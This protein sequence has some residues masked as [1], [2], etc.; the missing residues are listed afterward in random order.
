MALGELDVLYEAVLGRFGDLAIRDRRRA[1]L[2][3]L[4]LV[5]VEDLRYDDIAFL[6]EVI[7][8]LPRFSKVR[9]DA[10]H[11]AIGDGIHMN[12]HGHKT[13]AEIIYPIVKSLSDSV[14]RRSAMAH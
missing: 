3:A 10:S 5:R 8:L 1:R 4:D 14:L 7:D 9:N 2:V 11:F 13:M 6:S 12:K